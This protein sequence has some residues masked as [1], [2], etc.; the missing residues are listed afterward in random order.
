MGRKLIFTAIIVGLVGIKGQQHFT[1][2]KFLSAVKGKKPKFK[3]IG[4]K[5][6]FEK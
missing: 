5:D 1:A 6:I 2:M 4:I 3:N